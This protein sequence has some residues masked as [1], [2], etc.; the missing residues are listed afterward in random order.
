MKDGGRQIVEWGMVLSGVVAGLLLMAIAVR[1]MHRLSRG[2]LDREHVQF[3]QGAR[4]DS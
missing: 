1:E 4:A 3:V 2:N